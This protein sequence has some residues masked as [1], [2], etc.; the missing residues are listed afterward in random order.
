MKITA[1]I[2]E[3]AHLEQL[4]Q[5]M[6]RHRIQ[7]GNR[8]AAIERGDSDGNA[9]VAQHFAERF[10]SIENDIAAMI[11][12]SVKDHPAYP[13]LDA[14]KGIG[15]GLSGALLAPIDIRRANSIS[16]LWRYA[17]QGVNGE[18]ERDRPRKG[19]KLPYNAGLKKTC[20]LIGTS[21]MRA[22]SPYRAEYDQAKEFY[23]VNRPDWTKGHC[24]M[25]AKR[26]MIK[27]FLSHL[28]IVWRDAEGLPLSAPYAAQHLGHDG[29]VPP[30]QYVPDFEY[31]YALR[32]HYA[33]VSRLA[34]DAK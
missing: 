3:L 6:Q 22:G 24:D 34:V 20:Y 19:E 9:D 28:W 2:T 15:P 23:T 31:S 25:A 21:F 8:I 10:G 12:D 16:A 17:G 5:G 30:W 1:S 13:W 4:R 29:I 14:V 26:K 27:M 32:E 18:G 33:Q 7:M 11:A